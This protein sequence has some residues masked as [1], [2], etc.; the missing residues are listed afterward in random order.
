MSSLNAPLLPSVALGH[1]PA[2]TALAPVAAPVLSRVRYGVHI[3]TIGLLI[4]ASVACEVVACPSATRLPRTPFW[5]AGVMS[6]RG[7][8]LPIFDL[9]ALL[10]LAPAKPPSPRAGLILDRGDYAACLLIDGLPT[11]LTPLEPVTVTGPMSAP[12]QAHVT[13]AYRSGDELWFE[14]DHRGLFTELA[15]HIGAAH[16]RSPGSGP[17]KN[18]NLK[19]VVE[20]MHP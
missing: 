9:G 17:A 12:L 16:S 2:T 6:L 8:L 15:G 4:G 19:N 7:S 13:A 3:G 20:E 1:R 14:L 18:A 10:A 5:F 11:A